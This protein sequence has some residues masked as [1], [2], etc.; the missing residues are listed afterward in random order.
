MAFSGENL[1]ATIT[2]NGNAA[3]ASDAIMSTGDALARLSGA[4]GATAASA[5]AMSDSMAATSGALA[6][7]AGAMA[8]TDAA[9]GT[10]AGTL[11]MAAGSAGA[12][13]E[14]AG[15][16]GGMLSGL[17]GAIGGAGERISGFIERAGDMVA[18]IAAWSIFQDVTQWVHNL[19]DEL[20]NLN[21]NTEKSINGWQY[22]FGSKS[23]A[24][25]L[26]SWSSQ[27]SMNIPFT[28]QDLMT[29]ITT[30]GAAGM[31]PQQVE[32]F[33]PYL[34]DIASTYGSAAYGGKGTTLA[35]SAQAVR[36]AREGLSRMLKYD[37]NI[38]P[39]QLVP[40]GL[41]M[42][43]HGHITDPNSV[44]RA[45]EN[46]AN[47]KHLTGASGEM[48]QTTWWGGFSSATD[49]LQNFLLS[50][51][52]TDLN[53]NIRAGS[54]F[55]MLKKDLFGLMDWFDANQGQINKFAD[56]LSH[57]F[58]TVTDVA[59]GMLGQFFEW[60]SKIGDKQDVM[61]WIVDV[62]DALKRVFVGAPPLP[63]FTGEPKPGTGPNG[64]PASNLPHQ[65]HAGSLAAGG[66]GGRAPADMHNNGAPEGVGW[67]NLA[68]IGGLVQWF[69]SIM[70]QINWA[71]LQQGL[72][73]LGDGWS[74]FM[75]GFNSSGGAGT[76]QASA[77]VLGELVGWFLQLDAVGIGTTLSG[78]GTG[79]NL[80]GQVLQHMK[81][82]LDPITAGFNNLATVLERLLHALNSGNW[83]ELQ[84]L[85][86][87]L[88]GGSPGGHS[89]GGGHGNFFTGLIPPGAYKVFG[90]LGQWIGG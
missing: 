47:A 17:T 11:N 42:D 82:A 90:G 72:K 26:A 32:Q 53:G 41:V 16:A 27:F 51:G 67:E 30:F 59:G 35:Q 13:G 44:Y 25:E 21:V 64:K 19:S 10:M 75:K 7:T 6:D 58:G 65:P 79:L 68:V 1:G 73:D 88:T 36:M 76:L 52:G 89:S 66:S 78:I 55:D 63:P 37:L 83:K 5:A 22:L 20:F 71:P 15:G 2:L 70:N 84:Q 49:K 60:L 74:S 48:A 86:Q 24:T 39:S 46:F 34:S 77:N 31:T 18:A 81:G 29:A 4:F 8:D 61:A 14:A 43:Q 28:R 38:S 50:V 40:Y 45:L 85:W 33:M 54:F 62:S 23:N 12:M 69:Q 9:A 3:G 57:L 87:D 56:V 80:V